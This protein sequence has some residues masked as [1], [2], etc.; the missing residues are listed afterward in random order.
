MV[1]LLSKDAIL[2]FWADTIDLQTTD[3]G[4]MLTKHQAWVDYTLVN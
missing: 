1:I 2:I 4:N 3:N